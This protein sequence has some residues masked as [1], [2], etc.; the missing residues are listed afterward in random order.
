MVMVGESVQE[1]QLAHW[2]GTTTL[3][4]NLPSWLNTWFAIYPSS[5]SLIAQCGAVTLVLGS[6][7]VSQYISIWRPRQFQTRRE[8]IISH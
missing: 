3:N 1:M 7:L 2:I 5:E 8:A 6:Y 4:I